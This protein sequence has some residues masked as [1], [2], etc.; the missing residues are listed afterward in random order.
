ML[1][2]TRMRVSPNAPPAAAATVVASATTVR[3]APVEQRCGLPSR[4]VAYYSN[5]RLDKSTACV[6]ARGSSTEPL[7]RAGA[8]THVIFAHVLPNADGLNVTFAQA[9]D[10]PAVANLKV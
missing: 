5:R 9:R 4:I 6:E 7:S 2:L 8:A 1:G 10:K 3:A